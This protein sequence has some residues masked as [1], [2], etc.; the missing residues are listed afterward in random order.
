MMFSSLAASEAQ[1]RTLYHPSVTIKEGYLHK[2]KAEGLHLVT[3]FTFKKRYFWLSS[4]TLSYSKSPEWQ[5]RSSIPI[6]RICAV[7]RVDEN[8]FQQPHMMQIITQDNEGQLRTMY[9][10][11]KN[12]NELNQWLS[13]IRKASI[14]NER[15]LPFCHPGAFRG[16]RWSCC[17]Q[18]DRTARGCSRTHSAVTLGDW[19]DPL[20]PDAETQM[21]YGQ[22]LLGRDSL[23]S[24]CAVGSG[25]WAGEVRESG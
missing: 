17:L 22:L 21:V 23:R 4:E 11:C 15:M 3:R 12:V 16:N 10:Q 14:Y 6:Q 13:A 24:V 5:V 18:P 8:A 25:V 19:S 7:E 20:D 9:I 2:R 1:P